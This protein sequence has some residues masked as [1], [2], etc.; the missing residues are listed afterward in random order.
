M[1][2]ITV[3][4]ILTL[5]TVL[6]AGCLSGGAKSHE[7]TSSM[8][9]EGLERTWLVHLPE[10]F[11]KSISRPL[12]IVL[13]GGGGRARGMIDLTEGGFDELA[14]REGFIVCYPQG[15]DKHWNDGR[16]GA[17]SRASQENVNDVGFISALI[18]RLVRDLNVDPKRVYV[19]GISNGA[20]MSYRLGWEL[21]SK[22]AAIAP[23]AGAM[24]ENLPERPAPANPVSVLVISG[25]DDPLVPYKGGEVHLYNKELGRVLSVPQ[26]VEHWV[27]QNGCSTPPAIS[28]EPDKDPNDGTTITREIYSQ[29]R[30][31]SEVILYSIEGGGHT[32]PG[33]FQYLSEKIIGRTCRDI[34]ANEII[35]N[36]FKN[37]SR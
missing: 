32:W 9:F 34:D 31:G 16:P 7:Y 20:M 18:D 24:P 12:V 15:V 28:Q 35:W 23:V 21:S 2:R 4:L 36:F 22:I 14:D 13:H 26:S 17:T 30:N 27:R 29:G 10:G 11:D 37:H 19:T 6:V 1:I 8:Q 25:T 3:P 5:S 33:G